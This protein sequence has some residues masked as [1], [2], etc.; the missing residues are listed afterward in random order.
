MVMNIMH[1]GLHFETH[2]L[3]TLNIQSRHFLVEF[4]KGSSLV[5]WEYLFHREKQLQ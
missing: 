5:T 1:E 4:I 3:V 2:P